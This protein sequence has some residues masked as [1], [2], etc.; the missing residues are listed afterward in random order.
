MPAG[1]L[2]MSQPG[3]GAVTALVFALT[4]GDVRRFRR[5]KTR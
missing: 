1:V 4:I 5:A 2:L 3:V